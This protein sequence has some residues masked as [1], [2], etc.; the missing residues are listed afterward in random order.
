MNLN[1]IMLVVKCPMGLFY[2]TPSKTCKPCPI[3]FI[4]KQE[5]SL[6]CDACPTNSS[7]LVEGSKKCTGNIP[8]CYVHVYIYCYLV[9]Y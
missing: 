3:G 2:D 6:Q 8:I 5:G 4:S 1:N 7:T 9:E